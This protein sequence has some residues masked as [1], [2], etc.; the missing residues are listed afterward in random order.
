MKQWT[1]MA[2]E[3]TMKVV[4]STRNSSD[5]A[6]KQTTTYTEKK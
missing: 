1:T 6:T 3:T 5:V 4:N 2:L